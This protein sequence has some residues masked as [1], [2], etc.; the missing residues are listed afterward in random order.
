[1]SERLTGVP[2]DIELDLSKSGPA[3]LQNAA[4]RRVKARRLGGGDGGRERSEIRS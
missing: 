4:Y 1:M 2:D 3:I